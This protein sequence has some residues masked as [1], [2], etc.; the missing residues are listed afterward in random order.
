MATSRT[1]SRS[2]AG[3]SAAKRPPARSG[4][5][6]PRAKRPT[7]RRPVRRGPGPVGKALRGIWNLLAKGVG[8]L[9]RA[10]GRT[11]DIEAEV[12][13]DGVAFALIAIGVV[14]AAGIWWRTGGPVSEW[15][16]D[17][18]RTVIGAGAVAL[19]LVLLVIGVALMRSDPQPDKRPRLILGSLLFT[20]ALLGILHIFSALPEDNEHRMFAGGALGYVSGGLLTKGVSAWVALPLLA[21][22]IG[23]SVLV[24]TG[25][26]IKDIPTRLRELGMDPDDAE[27][28]SSQP[29]EEEQQPAEE[30]KPRRPSRRR[31]ASMAEPDQATLPLDEPA[32][33]PVKPR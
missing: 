28:D 12:R 22:A 19:P 13:R 30:P 14:V 2:R 24:F 4:G 20:L 1:T 10:M 15:L 7:A 9:A 16:E 32:P 29:A 23:F 11:R 31:Q 5:S 33:E 25:T 8:G 17:G 6:R 21:L 18:V 26:R 3:S 27:Y